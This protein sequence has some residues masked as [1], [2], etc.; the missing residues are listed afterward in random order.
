MLDFFYGHC[1]FV[2]ILPVDKKE[3]KYPDHTCETKKQYDKSILPS[4]KWIQLPQVTLPLIVVFVLLHR[5]FLPSIIIWKI[6]LDR[7][8]GGSDDALQE[9][10]GAN[11]SQLW[12]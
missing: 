9:Y 10:D 8:I 2:S 11:I 4:L 6:P 7:E 3:R 5:I 1:Y 12:K